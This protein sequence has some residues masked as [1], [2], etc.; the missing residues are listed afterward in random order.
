MNKSVIASIFVWLFVSACNNDSNSSIDADSQNAAISD[1]IN[2]SG[3]DS[4]QN[5]T[6]PD[7]FII[8]YWPIQLNDNT[9]AQ[10]AGTNSAI[11]FTY[12]VSLLDGTVIS[13]FQST[14]SVFA[15]M[16]SNSIYPIGFDLSLQEIGIKEGEEYAFVL[17][18]KYA[19]GSFEVS[20]FFPAN[21][22][23]IYK[24]RLFNVYSENEIFEV[25][26]GNILQYIN[27]NN[28]NDTIQNP[29]DTVVVYPEN[30]IAFK[31]I[32]E[33]DQAVRPVV[34]N[35]VSIT[36]QLEDINQNILQII[37]SPEEFEFVLGNQGETGN[38]IPGLEFGIRQLGVGERALIIIP[39]SQAYNESAQVIPV[40][41]KDE[42]V[43]ERVIPQY[44]STVDP[45]QILIFDL[46]LRNVSNNN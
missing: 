28:L 15:K 10:K 37:N 43:E 32:V 11:S 25:E 5:F 27:D 3:N 44:A 13:A 29:I 14:D 36:Y 8:Y 22:I 9:D 19:F 23:L 33:L 41:F 4:A 30:G 40:F 35:T 20:N 17:P 7:G 26:S 12:E 16:G 42:M 21:S 6:T 2:Q 46:I 39:S 45:Y 38:I 24:I 31:K 1:Y 34:G 18:S